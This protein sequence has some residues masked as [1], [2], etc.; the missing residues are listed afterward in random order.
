MPDSAEDGT[1]GLMLTPPNLI[2]FS[3]G[4]GSF[5]RHKALIDKT[6]AG[7]MVYR[8]E[9]MGLDLDMPADLERYQAM[10]TT[11]EM[12]AVALDL[13]TLQRNEPES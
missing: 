8:S 3:F 13:E 7:L 4:P 12:P 1:N 9:R 2:P 6:G 5:N 10:T 11:R